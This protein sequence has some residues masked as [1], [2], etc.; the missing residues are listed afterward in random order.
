MMPSHCRVHVDPALHSNSEPQSVK[1]V[2]A[3]SQHLAAL[4]GFTSSCLAIASSLI[5]HATPAALAEP[6]NDRWLMA[7]QVVDGLPPP[8]AF[9]DAPSA[10]S[11]TGQY[12]GSD[13]PEQLYLVYVNGDS[14]RLLEQV[15]QIEPSALVQD[16]G[17]RRVILV[18]LYEQAADADQRA[19]ELSAQGIQSAVDPVSSLAFVPAG[20]SAPAA[21]NAASNA[22]APSTLPPAEFLSEPN[23]SREIEFEQIPSLNSANTIPNEP[24][25]R[26]SDDVPNNA[27]YLVIPGSRSDLPQMRERVILLGARQ[28]SVLEREAPRGPHVLVGPFVDRSAAS[29][30]NRFLRD[31]GMNSRV[32]FIR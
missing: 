31:F 25:I 28:D 10:P 16:Y 21:S 22:A 7:Q 23:T 14:A 27:F 30:W 8:P 11:V 3:V 32:Y 1:T 15:R 13:L 24:G 9:G 2:K 20:S 19:R 5:L 12:D 4:A 26:Y 18:G 29:R 6:L 17:G